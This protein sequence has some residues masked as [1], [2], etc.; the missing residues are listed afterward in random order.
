MSK[1][2]LDGKKLLRLSEEMRAAA[3]NVLKSM[4]ETP[5]KDGYVFVGAM[6]DI[7]W[8]QEATDAYED[9]VRRGE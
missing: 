8:L 6:N 1:V 7:E 5:G 2:R 3:R 9:Y 4:H